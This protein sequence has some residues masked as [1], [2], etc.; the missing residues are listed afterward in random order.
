MS[1]PDEALIPRRPRLR[2]PSSAASASRCSASTA[3][4]VSAIP[5]RC[6][7]ST[8]RVA[9]RPAIGRS[10]E[11]LSGTGRP[12][13]GWASSASVD[14]VGGG[15]VEH[16]HPAA[17]AGGRG[18]QRGQPGASLEPG[19]V[20]GPPDDVLALEDVPAA[21]AANPER[22]TRC[23]PESAWPRERAR[24]AARATATATGSGATR[25][26]QALSAG[27]HRQHH[28][29]GEEERGQEG[30]DVPPADGGR[31]VP[32]ERAV[33]RRD[34]AQHGGRRGARDR[35]RS[36]RHQ[37]LRAVRPCGRAR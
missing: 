26:S 1:L 8:S 29:E 14:G 24:S 5:R 22:A 6:S 27:Q 3:R 25:S 20:E 19:V 32:H 18:V 12:G 37:H 10:P 34:R 28:R 9:G 7:S 21:A 2:E 33:D 36:G 13:P 23:S 16:R 17:A 30:A 11:P 35:G 15:Q 31:A 4:T